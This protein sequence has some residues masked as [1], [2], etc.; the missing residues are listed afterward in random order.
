MA[1]NFETKKQEEPV[2]P[3]NVEKKKK[4]VN[5]VCSWCGREMGTK[6]V[7]NDT[8]TSHTICPECQEKWKKQLEEMKEKPS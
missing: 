4:I 3:D 2:A 7:D 5:I 8:S 6:E 1:E